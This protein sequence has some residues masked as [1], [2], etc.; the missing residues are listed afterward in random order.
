MLMVLCETG[1]K[2]K[3]FL[4]C[5]K[6]GRNKYATKNGENNKHKVLDK[7]QKKRKNRKFSMINFYQHYR[8]QNTCEFSHTFL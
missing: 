3:R 2:S 6:N 5:V 8:A 1:M 7:E 4:V